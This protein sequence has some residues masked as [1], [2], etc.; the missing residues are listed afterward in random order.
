[1]INNEVSFQVGETIKSGPKE[2][3]IVG[4]PTPTTMFVTSINQPFKNGDPIIGQTSSATGTVTAVYAD[5][6]IFKLGET[7]R[8]FNNTVTAVVTETKPLGSIKAKI[9][10]GSDWTGIENFYANDTEYRSS[11]TTRAIAM[12]VFSADD[13]LYIVTGG[14]GSVP[15]APDALIVSVDG[16]DIS[17]GSISD[18]VTFTSGDYIYDSTSD[19]YF[20]LNG[21]MTLP[22]AELDTTIDNATD[23]VTAGIK[24]GS[25]TPQNSMTFNF[26]SKSTKT[27]FE[28]NLDSDGGDK[29][30]WT[31]CESGIMN[32]GKLAEGSHLFQ[33]RTVNDTVVDSTP[34]TFSWTIG[35][36]DT[37]PPETT[38]TPATDGNS[39]T[40][41]SGDTTKSTSIS[42]PYEGLDDVAIA[43]YECSIDGSEFASCDTNPQEYTKLTAGEHTFSVRAID[44]SNNTDE[45]PAVFTWTIATNE[46]DAVAPETYIDSVTDG[47]SKS[48]EDGSTTTSTYALFSF[49]GDDNS[50]VSYYECSLDG[51]DF[52]EC[53]SNQQKYGDLSISEHTFRVRSVDGSNNADQTPAIFSWIIVEKT[54]TSSSTI[55]NNAVVCKANYTLITVKGESTCTLNNTERGTATQISAVTTNTTKEPVKE[56]VTTK[57]KTDTID[58][59]A[60]TITTTSPAVITQDLT[61]GSTATQVATIQKFL[62]TQEPTF[63]PAKIVN[64]YFGLETKAAIIQF[65]E[66]YAPE[67][68]KPLG[69]TKGTGYVG[70]LTRA[71]IN[72]LIKNQKS[73]TT[74]R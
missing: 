61:T 1:M 25:T 26:S 46:K 68:L 63:Y 42:V 33:V 47:I 48:F 18:K 15:A 62:A 14:I 11:Y 53:D 60:R 58:A 8:D 6:T 20:Y 12:P 23:G 5:Q 35:I 36:A 19:N 2:A 41:N 4:L 29:L 64:G 43:S 66:K 34:A 17:I 52:S 69:L 7:I 10:D 72:Q 21:E 30:T 24:N 13:A 73:T 56:V 65:Q 38:I 39:S 71:K 32:Y 44:T 74:T 57:T 37:T 3:V 31:A 54:N 55:K 28:C 9:V 40:I 16:N 67:I 45:S 51:K 22:V 27:G 70:P 59:T 49:K 50:N